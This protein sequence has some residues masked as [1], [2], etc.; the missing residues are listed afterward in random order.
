MSELPEHC[1][2]KSC[3]W[4]LKAANECCAAP[5]L[6]AMKQSVAPCPYVAENV[7]VKSS[8]DAALEKA[9]KKYAEGD[10]SVVTKHAFDSGFRACWELLN[11]GR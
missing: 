9:W 10:D 4:Y 11:G 6:E 7:E 5:S 2:V 8:F 1:T 3:L